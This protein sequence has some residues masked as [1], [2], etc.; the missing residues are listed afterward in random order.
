MARV[1]GHATTCHGFFCAVLPFLCLGGR[2]EKIKEITK[3]TK[4]SEK[5]RERKRERE[6]EKERE[7]VCVYVCVCVSMYERER[8][9]AGEG[10]R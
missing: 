2:K 5:K 3:G 8:E 4:N 7:C 6:R 1:C 10:D 9:E